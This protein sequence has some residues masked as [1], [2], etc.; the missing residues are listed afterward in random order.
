VGAPATEQLP[1]AQQPQFNGEGGPSVNP[2]P[3]APIRGGRK[4]I[5][6]YRYYNS[7]R[8]RSRRNGN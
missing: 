2:I 8:T 3:N 7:R 5:R 6:N 4:S 1:Q